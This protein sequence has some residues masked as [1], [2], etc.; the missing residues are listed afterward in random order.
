MKSEQIVNEIIHNG[1]L[2]LEFADGDFVAH[3]FNED[4]DIDTYTTKDLDKAKSW[5]DK[6]HHDII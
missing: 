1:D 3:C 6:N 4:G 5:I 2:I